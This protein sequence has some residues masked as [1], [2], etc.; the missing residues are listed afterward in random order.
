M[1]FLVAYNTLFITL[2]R[3]YFLKKTKLYP[4]TITSQILKNM[5]QTSVMVILSSPKNRNVGSYTPVL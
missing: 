4:P 2:P 1:E 5:A 3:P